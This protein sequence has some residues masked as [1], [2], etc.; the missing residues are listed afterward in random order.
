MWKWNVAGL[1]FAT[2]VA[3]WYQAIILFILLRKELGNLDG[4]AILKSFVFSSVAGV[5]MGALCYVLSFVLLTKLPNAL[6]VLVSVG[7][8]GLFYLAV[9]R[10]LKVEEYRILIDIVRRRK[11]PAA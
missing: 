9:S 6:N 2:A 5:A 7:A 10:L 11:L 1:A 3:G 8:G 4:R